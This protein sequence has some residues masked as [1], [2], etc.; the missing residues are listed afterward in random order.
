MEAKETAGLLMTERVARDCSSGLLET[1]S[2]K[3]W[4]RCQ[5]EHTPTVS[6]KKEEEEG[7][8]KMEERKWEGKEGKRECLVTK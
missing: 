1:T 4:E 2:N 7:R 8:W 6:K 3:L 5:E